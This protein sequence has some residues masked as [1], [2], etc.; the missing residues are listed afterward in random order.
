[1]EGEEATPA[2]GGEDPPAGVGVYGVGFT[3]SPPTH[4]LSPTQPWFN[5]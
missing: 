4:P 2:E 3:D 5:I 1:V